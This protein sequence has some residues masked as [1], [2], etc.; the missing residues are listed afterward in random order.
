MN[1]ATNTNPNMNMNMNNNHNNMNNMNNNNSH[2]SDQKD[3]QKE[4][5]NGYGSST[6][7]PQQSNTETISTSKS[8]D[9]EHHYNFTDATVQELSQN[10]GFPA[11]FVKMALIQAQ[12]DITF[13]AEILFQ[14]NEKTIK[15]INKIEKE[16]QKKKKYSS[17]PNFNTVL[18][19]MVFCTNKIYLIF[20]V[21]NCIP[22]TY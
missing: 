11:E 1:M 13:A 2:H 3:D 17:I 19:L 12:G 14:M 7:S 21:S 15:A 4:P 10:L 22:S 8:A 18:F 5:S 20:N 9:I 16:K 6:I